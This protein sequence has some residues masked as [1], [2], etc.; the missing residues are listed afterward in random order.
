MA[1]KQAEEALRKAEEAAARQKNAEEA[2]IR[3]NQK[4]V[5]FVAVAAETK[6]SSAVQSS[7]LSTQHTSTDRELTEKLTQELNEAKA[8]LKKLRRAVFDADEKALALKKKLDAALG[9]S[10]AALMERGA[11]KKQ[12]EEFEAKA[13]DAQNEAEKKLRDAQAEAEEFEKKLRDAQTDAEEFKKRFKDARADAETATESSRDTRTANR[14]LARFSDSDSETKKILETAE[15]EIQKAHRDKEDADAR[16]ASA[17]ARAEDAISRSHALTLEA[18]TRERERDACVAK[19]SVLETKITKLEKPEKPDVKPETNPFRHKAEAVEDNAKQPPSVADATKIVTVYPVASTQ[20]PEF[21]RVE[22]PSTEN[23]KSHATAAA[24]LYREDYKILAEN[25]SVLSLLCQHAYLDQAW[26]SGTRGDAL[27]CGQQPNP[28]ARAAGKLMVKLTYPRTVCA[29][30]WEYLLLLC[31]AWVCCILAFCYVS[32]TV[33]SITPGILFAPFFPSFCVLLARIVLTTD[34]DFKNDRAKSVINTAHLALIPIGFML[35]F[36]KLWYDADG[37]PW[38][39]VYLF[40]FITLT[41]FLGNFVHDVVILMPMTEYAAL[42]FGEENSAYEFAFSERKSGEREIDMRT[43]RV[44]DVPY[45]ATRTWETRGRGRF[46]NAPSSVV[47]DEEEDGGG[48]TDDVIRAGS[49]GEDVERGV[50]TAGVVTAGVDTAGDDTARVNTARVDTR[51]VVDTAGVDSRGGVGTPMGAIAQTTQR[52]S[53]ASIGALLAYKSPRLTKP[54]PAQPAQPRGPA[55]PSVP[56]H[57]RVA[58][59]SHVT[60]SHVALTAP[61]VPG[62]GELPKP[63]PPVG[64]APVA[65]AVPTAG[66]SPLFPQRQAAARP[67]G[68]NL[69]A[70]I[71]SKKNQPGSSPVMRGANFGAGAFKR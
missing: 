5:E 6:P 62:F 68:S 8:Q 65:R 18:A 47:S 53:M 29:T 50:D 40:P 27:R 3:L 43:R 57:P 61:R 66:G 45:V 16:A 19:I 70:D 9:E 36:A 17:S 28:M 20:S 10:A 64:A 15:Y 51:G 49:D 34:L 55:P 11:F 22:I 30:W 37:L 71:P 21:K 13:R 58:D 54:A 33:L 52:P 48:F 26:L 35:F 7:V 1:Q 44:K 67:S 23:V 31:A 32:E 41:K 46:A 39:L 25:V 56:P 24:G 14:L 12:A 60:A 59:Y 42:G 2:A 38:W 4:L 69:H 63:P